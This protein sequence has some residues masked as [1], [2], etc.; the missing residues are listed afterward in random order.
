MAVN[1]SPSPQGLRYVPCGASHRA[2][3]GPALCRG[4]GDA[5]GTLVDCPE[6]RC[7]PGQVPGEEGE[8]P[9]DGSPLE[10]HSEGQPGVSTRGEGRGRSVTGSQ[11]L[12]CQ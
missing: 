10:G 8:R 3:P 5:E 1:S 7:G 4:C 11:A 9:W 12:T 6:R 2:P